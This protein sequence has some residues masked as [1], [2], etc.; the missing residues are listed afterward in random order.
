MTKSVAKAAGL[1][2]ALVCAVVEQESSWDPWSIRYE[3]D[4]FTRYVLP[5]QEKNIIHTDTEARARA[6]S[7]GLMQLMGQVAREVGYTGNLAALCAPATGLHW[8]CIHLAKKFREAGGDQAKALQLWNGGG[9]PNYAAEV[10]ARVKN[11][12]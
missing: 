3:P 4:F 5:L 12:A 6:F 11:Y 1:D 9:N 10:L 2:G 7:W 8:G